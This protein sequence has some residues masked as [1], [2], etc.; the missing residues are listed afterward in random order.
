MKYHLCLSLTLLLFFNT[1]IYSQNQEVNKSLSGHELGLASGFTTGSGFSYRYWPGKF[2][3]QL[4]TIPPLLEDG[5]LDYFNGGVTGLL[6]LAKVKEGRFFMYAS[7]CFISDPETYTDYF[8]VDPLD[9]YTSWYEQIV[10]QKNESFNAGLGVGFDIFAGKYIGIDL[11]GGYGLRD[12]NRS[13]NTF[14]T[15]EAGMYFRFWKKS[16]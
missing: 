11:M 6:Q 4:T 14:F 7:G 8:P 12:I 13:I 15:I 10:T 1:S 16:E 9:P 5:K 3:L 2:G